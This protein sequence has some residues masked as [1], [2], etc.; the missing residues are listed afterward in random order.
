MCC[1]GLRKK[2]A[3]GPHQAVSAACMETE[4]REVCEEFRKSLHTWE[5][6]PMLRSHNHTTSSY[7][8]PSYHLPQMKYTSG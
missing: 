3:V 2:D 7:Q 8:Q 1:Q 4:A 6:V 5:P